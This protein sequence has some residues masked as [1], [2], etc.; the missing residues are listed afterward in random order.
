MHEKHKEDFLL[1]FED[2]LDRSGFIGG[3]S[4][5]FLE[6]SLS[7]YL[8][9]KHVIACSSGTSALI[10]GLIAMRELGYISSQIFVQGNSFQA[11]AEAA[12]LAGFKVKL[13]DV[14]LGLKNPDKSIWENIIQKKSEKD[15]VML[16]HMNGCP[17]D[18]ETKDEEF[19][20]E[21]ASQAIGAAYKDNR[22]V[23]S[24]GK[25]AALSFYPGKNLGAF[26]D[27]GAIVSN[28]DQVAALA[29]AIIDHGK[30]KGKHRICG[31]T[32]RLDSIQ[33]SIL[34]KKLAYLD[35]CNTMRHEIAKL[36]KEHI[37]LKSILPETPD[38]VIPN[39]HIFPLQ[40]PDEIDRNDIQHK[41]LNQFGVQT[42][43]HYEESISQTGVFGFQNT[44]NC[45][46]LANKLISLPI[47]PYMTEAEVSYV[48]ESVNKCLS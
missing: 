32:F 33:A 39:W 43:I 7:E 14:D 46:M 9:V 12:M 20:I 22:R 16:V 42:S 19:I 41:L 26:G 31:G 13:F 45:D 25:F 29:R 18:I 34:T 36:Y 6:H 8:Q 15:G 47:F 24:L 30:I 21:D 17:V 11:S 37:R 5:R 35:E 44:P 23:G 1:I 38:S 2:A 28:D 27:G 10:V 48:A 40:V 3:E 4:V